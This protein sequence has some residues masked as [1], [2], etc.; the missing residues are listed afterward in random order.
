MFCLSLLVKQYPKLYGFQSSKLSKCYMYATQTQHCPPIPGLRFRGPGEPG[1]LS[2]GRFFWDCWPPNIESSASSTIMFW[3]WR[4]T[5]YSTGSITGQE[6]QGEG[7]CKCKSAFNRLLYSIAM[8][9]FTN[10]RNRAFSYFGGKAS[11][12]KGEAK[13]WC[14][15]VS[16]NCMI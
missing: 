13:C 8:Y 5:C 15:K 3:E 11:A 14:V 12:G 10:K 1:G 6:R 16:Q 9:F 2:L 7:G 4:N